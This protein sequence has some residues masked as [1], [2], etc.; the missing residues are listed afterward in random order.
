MSGLDKIRNQIL[1]EANSQSQKKLEEA[2]K[3]ADE[4]V[5]LVKEELDRTWEKSR[6][7]SQKNVKNYEERIQSA[8]EIQRR[9][10]VLQVK[11]ELIAQVLK[12]AYE[13]VLNLPEKEY[14]CMLQKL[15]ETH[16]RGADGILYL[17][18]KDKKRLPETFSKEVEKLAAKKGGAVKIA[19]ETKNID[20]G[21]ILVYGGMEENC[22]IQSML[23]IKKDELSDLIQKKLF[24]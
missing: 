3:K 17:S 12:K 6:Q 10:A 8:G 13:E 7:Q 4:I 2:R 21:F 5:A 22:T 15:F 1:G 23:E 19:Q 24:A 14:F 20:G 18:E 16:V 9:N 11:R